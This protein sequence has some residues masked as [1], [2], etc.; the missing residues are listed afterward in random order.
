MCLAHAVGNAVVRAYL[1][2]DLF[3]IRRDLMQQW[4]DFCIPPEDAPVQETVDGPAEDLNGDGPERGGFE[5]DLP[6]GFEPLPLPE[7]ES[8]PAA[9]REP[10]VVVTV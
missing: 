10:M 5:W 2:S 6:G 8:S 4:A 3:A 7:P 9:R 1:R